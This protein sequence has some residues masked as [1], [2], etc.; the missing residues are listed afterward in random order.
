[1]R[2]QRNI[3]AVNR[4]DYAFC[5][6]NTKHVWGEQLSK[7]RMP[8]MTYAGFGSEVRNNNGSF[9]WFDFDYIICDEM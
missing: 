1:M 8:V 4:M 5:D 3:I 6:Y 7:G 9:K 2:I